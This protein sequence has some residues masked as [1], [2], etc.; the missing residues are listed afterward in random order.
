MNQR[1]PTK[2]Y[3][4]LLAVCLYELMEEGENILKNSQ[5]TDLSQ[6]IALSEKIDNI[7]LWLDLLARMD[8]S[9]PQSTIKL[10]HEKSKLMTT[11]NIVEMSNAAAQ[12]LMLL[13]DH[14]CIFSYPT[15][16]QP[17]PNHIPLLRLQDIT[18]DAS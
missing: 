17:R 9:L 8:S 16:Q 13:E 15:H 14:Y 3:A 18:P 10:L 11:E 12:A 4:R 7:R 1:K 6:D 5:Q 2:E